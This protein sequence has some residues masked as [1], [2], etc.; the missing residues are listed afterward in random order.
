MAGVMK[1]KIA[2]YCQIVESVEKSAAFYKDVLGLPMRFRNENF[3]DFEMPGGA[4][5]ALWEYTHV[6][7][8]VGA[9]AIGPKGNRSMG[10]INFKTAEDL[11]ATVAEWKQK[12]VNFIA[13]PKVFPYGAYAAY[14]KDPDGY[15][16]EL[17]TWVM[18]P[19]TL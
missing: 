8:V 19:R 3:A 6:A 2:D 12:G 17:Y 7:Q 5:L 4:R 13:G 1:L 9:E 16:W 18:T 14:F 11:D 10:M 15:L